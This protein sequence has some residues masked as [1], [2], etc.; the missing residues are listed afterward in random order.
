MDLR[1][2]WNYFSIKHVQHLEI[3]TLEKSKVARKMLEDKRNSRVYLKKIEFK[4]AMMIKGCGNFTHP[5]MEG[6][7]YGHFSDCEVKFWFSTI[8]SPRKR[9]F[10]IFRK[11]DNAFIGFLGLKHYNKLLKTSKLG[12][13]FDA[14]QVSQG[15]GYEAMEIL[16][17]YYF[18][19]LGFKE[20]YL[21]VNDFNIR[22]YKLY[23]KL[24]FVEERHKLEVI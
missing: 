17:D 15:Y 24:V 1:E 12:I 21:D 8:T 10:S 2:L 13:V 5:W 6:Y 9:Y 22:A 7:N 3:W 4:D 16:L 18:D 11:E 23:K 20:L 19:N 14:N